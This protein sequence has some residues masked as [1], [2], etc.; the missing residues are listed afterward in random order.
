[1]D[2]KPVGRVEGLFRYPVKSMGGEALERATL[3][4]HGVAG[5]RRFALRRLQERG[6]LPWLTA[7]KLPELLLFTPLSRGGELPDQVRTPDG[8]DLEIFSDEL[9]SDIGRRHGAPVQMM[10]LDKGI[11]DDAA[12][13][14]IASETVAEVCRLGEQPADVRRFRPNVMVRGAEPFGEDRWVG[15]VLRF[16]DGDD[17]AAVSVI[18]LDLRCVM[19]NLEPKTAQPAPK[20]LRAVMQT[21]GG[22]AGVYCTVLRQGALAV[23]Q[24]VWWRAGAA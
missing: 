23:G 7:S 8:R 21:N 14:V 20:L 5:D 17:A 22:N 2:W 1:M 19:I 10:R 18:M 11:F 15:G 13:S 12:L 9:A 24:P 4:W 6:G 16:G 3:G